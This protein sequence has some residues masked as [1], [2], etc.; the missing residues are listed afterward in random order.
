MGRTGG[1][2]GRIE[3]EEATVRLRHGGLHIE[4][5]MQVAETLGQLGLCG[6][7]LMEWRS[8]AHLQSM[9][10]ERLRWRSS[11]LDALPPNVGQN[12]PSKTGSRCIMEDDMILLAVPFCFRNDY[13]ALSR[14]NNTPSKWPS[15]L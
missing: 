8:F 9:T 14:H 11:T 5:R 1:G 6:N 3:A 12:N 15:E 7:L 13:Y 4:W 2:A 10:S